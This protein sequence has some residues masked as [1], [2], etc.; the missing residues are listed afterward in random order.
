M[1]YPFTKARTSNSRIAFSIRSVMGT[2]RS[3]APFPGVSLSILPFDCD[4]GFSDQFVDWP[5]RLPWMDGRFA[6]THREN[7]VQSIAVV[8]IIKRRDSTTK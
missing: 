6:Y 5:G 4:L 3:A 1:T 7:K 8:D 2:D